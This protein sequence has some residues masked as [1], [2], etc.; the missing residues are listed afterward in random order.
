MQSI[1]PMNQYLLPNSKNDKFRIIRTVK[2]TSLQN[3]QKAFE[4]ENVLLYWIDKD[5][6]F[7]STRLY[8]ILKTALL[9]K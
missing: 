6:V 5:E 7:Q 1:G 4:K 2:G 9:L 3:S 8:I